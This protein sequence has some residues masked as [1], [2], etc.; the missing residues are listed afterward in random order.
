MSDTTALQRLLTWLS[1][2]F[3][4]GGFAWSPRLE[5]A[6]TDRSVTEAVTLR[7]WIAGSVDHGALRTDAI[8]LAEAHRTFTV[9]S[10]L[11]NVA[12]F[13]LAL[14][15]SSERRLETTLSGEAFANAARAWPS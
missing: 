6:I 13:A 15:T 12:D 7:D 8:L 2:A 1:P 3:P 11:A 10:R 9:A 5:P 4:V 14:T